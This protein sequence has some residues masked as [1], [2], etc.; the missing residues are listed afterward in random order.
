MSTT[1]PSG[2]NSRMGSPARTSGIPGL[3]VTPGATTHPMFEIWKT[4]STTKS[5]D[6]SMDRM[7][8]SGR[9]LSSG[10]CSPYLAKP[11][12][13]KV[14][15]RFK[16]TVFDKQPDPLREEGVGNP[17]WEVPRRQHRHPDHACDLPPIAGDLRKKCRIDKRKFSVRHALQPVRPLRAK[18]QCRK[19]HRSR[20]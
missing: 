16:L 3:G 1:S 13:P 2:F 8:V 6:G 14:A 15:L 20:G 5:R 12:S 11:H 7:S 19:F 10:R 9:I 4:C 18:A 17:A